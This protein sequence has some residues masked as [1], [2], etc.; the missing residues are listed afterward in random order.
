MKIG[1]SLKLLHFNKLHFNKKAQAASIN[2]QDLFLILLLSIVFGRTYCLFR[3]KH[4]K[5]RNSGR[6]GGMGGYLSQGRLF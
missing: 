2:E 3:V 6:E 5:Q 1:Q 4:Q